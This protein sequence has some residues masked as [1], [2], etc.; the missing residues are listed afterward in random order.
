[1]TTR[2]KR[3]WRWAKHQKRWF[4]KW[5]TYLGII[6]GAILAF[7]GVTG[8]ILVFQDEIDRALNR[9][10][11]EVVAH[12]RKLSFDELVPLIKKNNPKLKFDYVL[13]G[14][15]DSPLEAYSTLNFKTE[16]QVFINPYNGK[17]SGKRIISSSFIRVVMELHR[18][19]LIPTIG[20]YIV[21]MA[22][23]CMLILTISGLRLWVPKKWSS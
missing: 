15:G 6:A 5:H 10:L 23:L 17:V 21:G 18:T 13:A 7:V 4:G 11:F 9:E 19:L 16:E 22:S 8:S 20:K 2:I 3:S 14:K 12:Q 1:M